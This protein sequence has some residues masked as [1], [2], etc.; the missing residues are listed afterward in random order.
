MVKMNKMVA[1]EDFIA[2]EICVGRVLRAEVRPEARQPAYKLE[3]DF[4]EEI[5]VKQ[6]SAQI[7]VHY[8]PTELVGELVLGVVNFPPKQVGKC[9]SEVLVLGVHDEAG[10]VRLV[11]PEGEV[12]LGG[13]VL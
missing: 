10:G 11:Q 1:W 2:V 13:R 6:S 7:T 8:T 3:I 4:G 9:M 12:P 5:G